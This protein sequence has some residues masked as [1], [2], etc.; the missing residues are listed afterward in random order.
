MNKISVIVPVYNAEKTIKKTLD[1]LLR[2]T[3]KNIE[4]ICV[5]DGSK[6][7]SLKVL[8]G[9]AQTNPDIVKIFHQDNQGVSVARNA[10]IERATGEILM[11]VDA[12]D[13]LVPYACQRVN[14][15]LT[16]TNAEVFTFGLK[17]EPESSTPLGMK[18]ELKPPKKIYEHF[19]SDLLF[20]DKARP[21]TCRTAISK[22]L[23]DR[24]RI[25]F[26]PGVALGEDQIIYFLLYPLAKRVALSPEQLYI[27]NMDNESATHQNALEEK[28]A[29]RRL[30]QHFSVI[31]TIMRE[32]KHRNL[33]KLCPCE[34]LDW[35]LDFV[36]FDMNR[37]N[38]NNLRNTYYIKLIDKLESY[39]QKKPSLVATSLPTKLCLQNIETLTINRSL[40]NPKRIHI[41]F[42]AL[43]Y[44][45][46]YGISRCIQQVFISLG[47]ITKW[48]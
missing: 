27:Y 37:L 2:Q 30:E 35:M 32:W 31:T 20:K 43:F 21:Y 14:E 38:D 40:N 28:G 17:C 41:L 34:L 25:Q 36:L 12:D 15:V 5:D 24:E 42:L 1:S 39:Y 16:D 13:E 22:Q 11:F 9:Y 33:V 23:I 47:L 46:R 4:I 29:L 7:A 3:F 8:Q 10:G 6:D 45:K 19:Q 44:L 18:K 26:E 48:K